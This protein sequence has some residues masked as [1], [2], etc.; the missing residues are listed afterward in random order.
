[1]INEQSQPGNV[2]IIDSAREPKS[3]AKPNRL[4]II[5]VGVVL[6]LGLAFAYVFV[7][8][9]FDDTVKTPEDIQKKNINER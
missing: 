1:M 2:L 6:G 7:K 9:Y 4:L 8:N 5:L 3:P